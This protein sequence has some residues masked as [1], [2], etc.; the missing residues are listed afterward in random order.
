M[1]TS[2]LDRVTLS[3]TLG[4]LILL[5]EALLGKEGDSTRRETL[6]HDRAVLAVHK[7]EIDLLPEGQIRYYQS[8]GFSLPQPDSDSRPGSASERASSVEGDSSSGNKKSDTEGD[9]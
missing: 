1:K 6:K 5:V 4:R 8:R 3:Y 9:E 7:R 2:A